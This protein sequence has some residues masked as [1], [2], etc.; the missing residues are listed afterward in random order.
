MGGP[1]VVPANY[2]K[3]AVCVSQTP[4]NTNAADPL[5]GF[6]LSTFYQAYAGYKAHGFDGQLGNVLF[7]SPWANPA[8]SRL[9]P[10]A[11]QGAYLN[12]TA[13]SKWTFDGADMF[14]YENRTSSSFT[15]QTLLTSYPAGNNGL[16]SNIFLPNGNGINTSGFVMGKVGYGDATMPGF[17]ADGYFYGV[18]DLVNMWWFDGSY[19]FDN[20]LKPWIALQGGTNQNAGQSYIGKVDSQA[21]GAQLGLN[22]TRNLQLTAG[23]DHIP[24]K[25]PPVSPP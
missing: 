20:P 10:A 16:G 19:M 17:S 23:Y 5:P 4:P 12:Y 2:I 7:N 21:L 18:S 6:T 3:G 14:A 8:D 24:W 13:A 1:C 22:V 15:Q 11:C 9:K 25:T